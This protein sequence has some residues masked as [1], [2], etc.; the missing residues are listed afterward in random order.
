MYNL[1]LHHAR[2]FFFMLMTACA[3][4]PVTLVADLSAFFGANLGVSTKLIYFP[5]PRP[6]M[7]SVICPSFIY[8]FFTLKII[9]F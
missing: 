8:L 7:K 2:I 4:D 5:I 3:S 1:L 6:M 9:I